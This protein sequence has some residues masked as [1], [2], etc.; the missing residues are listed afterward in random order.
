MNRLVGTILLAGSLALGWL[1]MDLQSFMDR[2][3]PLPEEG[4]VY[5]LAPGTSLKALARDLH[6]RGIIEKPFYLVLVGRWQGKAGRLKAGEYLF[7][8][9]TTPQALLDQ[10][11]AGKVVR[12][13]FTLVEGWTFRQV[14]KALEARP[15]IGHT[16]AG[17]DDAQ[18]MVRLGHPGEHPE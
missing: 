5:D 17:L 8:P 4:V 3:L 15:E 1:L 9:G 16:L 6:A 10:I 11:A 18:V 12:H 7:L 13:S 14:R 2:P